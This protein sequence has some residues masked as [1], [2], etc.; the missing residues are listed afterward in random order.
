[1][2][3]SR[4]IRGRYYLTAGDLARGA[5]FD[6]GVC[7]VNMGFDIHTPDPREGRGVTRLPHCA[8]PYQVPYRSLLPLEVDHLLLAGRCISGDHAAHSS[9]RVTGNAVGMGEAAGLAAA[10]ALASGKL[11]AEI[12]VPAHL[13]RLRAIR[14]PGP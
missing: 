8:R 12:D 11:P 7:D 9:Y 10:V 14:F 1:M 3:E 6:D 5:R 4:R 13:A 2:R